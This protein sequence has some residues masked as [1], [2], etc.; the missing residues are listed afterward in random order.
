MF[1]DI[2]EE[3]GGAE[4]DDGDGF[5]VEDL[6]DLE[7]NDDI[8]TSTGEECPGI[9]EQAS[10]G[11]ISLSST[12]YTNLSHYNSVCMV[13]LP[14]VSFKSTLLS[15]R[16]HTEDPITYTLL[17]KASQQLEQLL[18]TSDSDTDEATTNYRSYLQPRK[19]RYSKGSHSK[20]N[21]H[22][23]TTK[24]DQSEPKPSTSD[25]RVQETDDTCFTRKPQMPYISEPITLHSQPLTPSLFPGLEPTIHFPMPDEPCE[26][27]LIRNGYNIL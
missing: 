25:Q 5:S 15:F 10:T 18:I 14:L 11:R 9:T 13:M 4:K 20:P 3:G 8:E 16:P 1:G 24:T 22:Q 2:E 17:Q 7:D 12:L 6:T 23:R 19:P 26:L 21:K 27:V